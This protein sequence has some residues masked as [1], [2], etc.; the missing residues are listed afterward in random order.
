MSPHE[1]ANAATLLVLAGAAFYLGTIWTTNKE[2][3]AVNGCPRR[4]C[5]RMPAGQGCNHQP[6]TDGSASGVSQGDEE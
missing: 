4:G 6:R 1:I 2:G 3:D 5:R